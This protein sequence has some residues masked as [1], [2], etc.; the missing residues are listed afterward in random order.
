MKVE[1]KR[2]WHNAKIGDVV[3]VANSL[4]SELVKS[5]IAVLSDQ[6]TKLV[7]R[8]PLEKEEFLKEQPIEQPKK[9]ANPKSKPKTNTLTR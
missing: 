4:G 2:D 3:I 7:K 6:E 8:I 5:C 9:K 1:F